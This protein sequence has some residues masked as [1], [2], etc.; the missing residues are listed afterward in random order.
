[1]KS[2]KSFLRKIDFFGVPFSFKYKNKEKYTTAIGGFF[3][4]LFICAALFLGIYYF[5]PFYNRKNYTTVY[6][7]LTMSE[8]ERISFGESKTG[9][10]IGLN[11]WT[12]YDGTTADQ[13]LK[14]EHYYIYYELIDNKYVKNMK[15]IGVHPCTKADFYNEFDET[16]D[17][18]QIYNY[19][20]LDDPSNAMEGI[21]TSP[22]FSYYQYE[23]NAKNNSKELLDKITAFMI[24]NDCKLQMYYVDNTIDIDD[25]EDPIKSYIEAVFIQLNPTMSIRR[26]IYFMN[27]HLYDDNYLFWVFGD[28]DEARYIKTIFSRYEEYSLYQGVN[29]AQGSSDYLNYAKVYIRADTKKIDVKRKYQKVMEFYADA[30]SLLIAVFEIL[31]IIFNFINNFWAEQK[32]AKKIFFFQDLDDN[33][34]S[35]KDKTDKIKELLFATTDLKEKKI[36]SRQNSIEERENNE[37]DI[38]K[39]FDNPENEYKNNKDKY[40]NI[41]DMNK[42]YSMK[43]KNIE[44]DMKK[45][46]SLKTNFLGNEEIMIYNSKKNIY[47]RPPHFL[48]K[49]SQKHLWN[50]RI[51]IQETDKVEEKEGY[52]NHYN[53]K[54]ENPYKGN[55]SRESG[56]LNIKYSRNGVNKIE[57]DNNYNSNDNAIKIDNDKKD[58]ISSSENR[59]LKSLSKGKKKEKIEFYFNIFEIIGAHLCK[60]CQSKN[61][62]LKND[63]NEKANNILYSKLDISNFVRNQL[64]FDIMHETILET[65]YIDIVNFLSRPNISLNQKEESELSLFYKTYKNNDFDIFYKKLIELTNK[66][67]IQEKEKKL[68]ELS[69]KYLRKF[70][71]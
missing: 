49:L 50:K 64:L 63:L 36:N 16:F 30:S 40:A 5:I 14:V 51:K 32:L 69:N 8:T 13:L 58:E 10:S 1:M 48:K 39:E 70:N 68:I 44:N 23:V 65:E 53:E 19:Q 15:A 29:R 20:C 55:L 59:G 4:V 31:V 66:P 21:Y 2:L 27:E 57:R 11:C 38:T 41:N 45:K 71:I 42:K 34:I 43:M 62:R 56:I 3:M 67:D 26:N 46:Y 25:Y 61:L 54:Y 28:D 17:G 9:F 52:N 12:G 47:F 33:N 6:Y 60:C 24:E 35:F 22:I 7:T 18:S 37:N